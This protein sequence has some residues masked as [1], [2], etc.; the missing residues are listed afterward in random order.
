[1][2][3]TL[4]ISLLAL[5]LGAI[6]A[7]TS[8]AERITVFAAASLKEALDQIANDFTDASGHEVVISYAGSGALARQI[9]AGAPADLFI[10]ANEAWMNAVEDAG[11]L[12]GCDR[13]DLLENDLVLVAHDPEIGAVSVDAELD[14]VAMLAGEKLAIALTDAVPAGQYGKVALQHLG[15]WDQVAPHLAEAENVRATLRLVERGETPLGIVYRSDLEASSAAH[16]IGQ[17]PADSHPLIIYPLGC[18]SDDEASYAFFDWLTGDAAATV[19]TA[20]GFR[21]VD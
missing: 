15:L 5:L 9:L 19:F 3:K 14:L 18:Q 7:G 1:M 16:L 4:L 21:I 6:G 12:T 2:R 17:F 10:S 20:A 8:H 11:L 13:R